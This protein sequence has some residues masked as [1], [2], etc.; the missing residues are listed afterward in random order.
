MYHLFCTMF[1]VFC[2]PFWLFHLFQILFSTLFCIFWL[3]CI[4]SFLCISAAI[5]PT[6]SV[7]YPDPYLVMPILSGVVPVQRLILR[8]LAAIWHVSV[9]HLVLC[10]LAAVFGCSTCSA[11][12]SLQI[13][14][15]LSFCLLQLSSTLFYIFLLPFCLTH[16]FCI[17]FWIICVP[18]HLVYLFC[19]LFFCFACSNFSS[20]CSAY[21]RCQYICYIYSES[22]PMYFGSVFSFPHLALRI[23]AVFLPAPAVQ[24]LVLYII[25]AVVPLPIVLCLVMCILTTV[26]SVQHIV[27]R[28]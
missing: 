8:N 25:T 23:L 4:P 2:L 10:I 26:P 22:F 13:V 3:L 24:H 7:S 1:C 28:I 17:L 14:F 18:F 11:H 27:L 16:L 12:C 5:L 20:T 9:L 21:F 19:I 6:P 15:W